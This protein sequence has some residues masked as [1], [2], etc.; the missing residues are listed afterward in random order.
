MGN[1][2]GVELDLLKESLESSVVGL[3]L[4]TAW[5]GGGNLGEI[6]SF[7]FEQPTDDR[8]K[9]FDAGEMPI[10]K[11]EF[12]DIDEYGSLSHGVVSWLVGDFDTTFFNLPLFMHG[13]L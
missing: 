12:Q 3:D 4:R 11:V 7:D 9:A 2:R 5:K 10:C 8:G 1:Q 13:Y 6:D